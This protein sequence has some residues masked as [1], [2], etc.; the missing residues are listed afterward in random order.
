MTNAHKAA[1]LLSAALLTAVLNAT[2]DHHETKVKTIELADQSTPNPW[3][4]DGPLPTTTTSTTTTTTTPPMSKLSKPRPTIDYSS[5]EP[6][7]GDLPP[8]YVKQRESGGNYGAYN[9]HGC[10]GQGCYGAWQFSGAWAGKL[11]LPQ[12]LS[13]ATPQ[14]QDDAARQLWNGGAGCGNWAACG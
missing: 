13:T 6:C 12:D 4:W 14:Q 5:M 1:A 3:A 8:C 10:G 7:G 2:P 11:G 9:P